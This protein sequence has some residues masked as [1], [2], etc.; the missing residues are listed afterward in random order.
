MC[1]LGKDASL[2]RVISKRQTA[3]EKFGFLLFENSAIRPEL[4]FPMSQGFDLMASE[5][6]L[7]GRAR[8]AFVETKVAL[9]LPSTHFAMTHGT[10]ALNE[11]KAFV[12][13]SVYDESYSGTIKVL[14]ENE[15]LADLH[16]MAGDKVA[17]LI[18]A[19]ICPPTVQVFK[20]TT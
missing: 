10:A 13:S 11:I 7:I 16:V 19:P 3:M 6:V 20:V 9:S 5:N 1:P 17:T 14:I 4:V 15:G 12:K 2:Q 18:I 8:R